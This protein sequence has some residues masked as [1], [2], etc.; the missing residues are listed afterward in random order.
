MADQGITWGTK[1]ET[2]DNLRSVL[3]NAVILPSV[4]FSVQQWQK[5]REHY[6]Q[7][8][9]RMPAASLIV[10][11]S[12]QNEDGANN[13]LAGA[14]KSCL[15]VPADSIDDIDAAVQTV[16]ESFGGNTDPDNQIL[17]QPM[18]TAVQMSGVVMTHDL[19]KGAPYYTINYDDESGVTDTITGGTGIQ[20]TVLIHR[21][22]RLS[23]VKSERLRR[24]LKASLELENLCEQVPL[25]I[26]FAVDAS[27]TVYIF[28][29]RRISI[30]NRWHPVTERRVSRQLEHVS[31]FLQLNLGEKSTVYGKR[32][33]LG[34][35]PDWNPAEIIGSF[36]R[37]L[38]SSLYCYLVTDAVWSEARALIGYH[39]V[40]YHPLM[41]VIGHHPYI[42]VRASFNSFLP[43][44][45]DP[46]SA[47]RLINAWINYLTQHPELHD[48]VEFEIAQTCLDFNFD[49]HYARRYG[50]VLNTDELCEYRRQLSALTFNAIAAN[51]KGNLQDSLACIADHETRQHNRIKAVGL[52]DAVTLL[53]E[54]R[55]IGVLHF[56]VIARHAFIAEALMRS[57]S[58]RGAFSA[59]NLQQWKQSIQTVSYDFTHDY[60][61]VLSGALS[62]DS[63][64][65]IYG[66][67]RP[68]TY[69]I[70]SLRYD[71]RVDLF[72]LKG[73]HSPLSANKKK[74]FRWA[75]EELSALQLLIEQER[76]SLS[77]DQ[78]LRYAEQ[79][80]A[81]R[82]YAKFVFTRD[83]SDLLDA[84]V[85]WGADVGLS[86]DD[87]SFL[88][89]DAILQ[90]VITPLLDDPD[91]ILLK[92]AEESRLRY[93]QAALLKLPHLI[94]SPE[95]I[96]IVPLHRAM[97]NFVTEQY[98]EADICILSSDIGTSVDLN[99]K[100][101][102]IEN[103]DP[104]YDWIF[105]QNIAGLIT[106]FGGTNSHMAIR[107]AE[108][109]VPAAIGCGEQLFNAL[110]H[111]R[112][113]VLNC[114]DKKL[115]TV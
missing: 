13:S 76:W 16:A 73:A 75:P 82:E 74:P 103:A 59:E 12:A 14:Y 10:R 58:E 48:K 50:G 109:C 22:T 66:H 34:S 37:P 49:Q 27:R 45:I 80:I 19:Q 64:M 42:D 81:G 30:C 9:R 86:R 97:P 23:K 92:E 51:C 96:Y 89:I 29:V 68:G 38:S 62:K 44:D 17:V 24:V 26:E 55:D 57:A 28:Q 61:S 4:Y 102:C 40:R 54:C 25:D 71:E 106:K 32:S 79:A 47:E 115:T 63:F 90:L 36:A 100:I 111:H 94:H 15:N 107:C 101:V 52:A 5:Q 39:H 84:L 21:N 43:D 3:Q 60:D 98:I 85:S 11:S 112:K 88:S 99:G 53:H 46:S 83:L 114:R 18:I 108:H 35:M 70:T 7:L 65:A 91:R 8:I 33:I 69:D 31:A 20:K 78:L 41:Y 95:D 87:L 77:A 93:D 104:G 110:V 67:L 56:A 6:L 72:K 1:A 2:L 113:V 105:I